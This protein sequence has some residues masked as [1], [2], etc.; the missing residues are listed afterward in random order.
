MKIIARYLLLIT[1]LTLFFFVGESAKASGLQSDISLSFTPNT[2][3]T[4]SQNNLTN[5]SNKEIPDENTII[6]NQKQKRLPKTG[7][8]KEFILIEIGLLIILLIGY[9][10]YRKNRGRWRKWKS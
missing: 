6:V 10:Y 8:S 9:Y 4:D 5:E 1:C 7:S 2:H 3:I